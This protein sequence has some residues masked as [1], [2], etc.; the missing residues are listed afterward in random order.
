MFKKIPGT[1]FYQ[2]NQNEYRVKELSFRG[3]SIVNT[4]SGEV[5]NARS[6]RFASRLVGVTP[7]AIT[8]SLKSGLPVR[9]T[10]LNFRPL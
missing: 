1:H 5:K 4:S 7:R 3:L 10:S 8:K 2:I 9:G 6:I